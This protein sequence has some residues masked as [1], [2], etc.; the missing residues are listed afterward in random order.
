MFTVAPIGS[1]KDAIFSDTFEFC[2]TASIVSGSVTRLDPVVNFVWRDTTPITG[3]LADEFSVRWTGALLASFVIG[4]AQILTV[5]Y[6]GAHW[7][8]VVALVA[9]ILTLVLR[10]SGLFGKQKELEERV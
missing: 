7:Q 8:M 10:P 4:F 6:V 5:S 3:S 2:V 9:I 1:T